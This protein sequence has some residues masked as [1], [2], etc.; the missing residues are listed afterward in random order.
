MKDEVS[1]IFIAGLYLFYKKINFGSA[2]SNIFE[3]QVK[4]FLKEEVFNYF[5]VGSKKLNEG[6]IKE[7]FETAL[8]LQHMNWIDQP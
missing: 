1:E 3:S 2:S 4:A 6:L 8:Y 5:C 7:H